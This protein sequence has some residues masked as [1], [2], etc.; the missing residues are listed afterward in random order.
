MNLKRIVIIIENIDADINELS[1]EIK[2][3]SKAIGCRHVIHNDT[4]NLT[5]DTGKKP[6]LKVVKNG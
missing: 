3:F 1:D 6:V 4:I 2:K 5:P